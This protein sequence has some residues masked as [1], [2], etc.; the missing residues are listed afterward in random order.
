VPRAIRLYLR[1]V[2]RHWWWL[3]LSAVGVVGDVG[4]VYGQSLS[5]PRWGWLACAAIGVVLAQF[6]AWD[7]MRAERDGFEATLTA[8]VRRFPDLLVS[9]KPLMYHDHTDHGRLLFFE[10]SITNQETDRRVVL[11]LILR[12][13]S[14][15][16]EADGWGDWG[17]VGSKLG[18]R[19]QEHPNSLPAPVALGPGEFCDGL[20]IVDAGLADIY[21]ELVEHGRDYGQ[22]LL[23]EGGPVRGRFELDVFDRIS[24]EAKQY[25]VDLKESAD[26]IRRLR[27]HI[28]EPA[29]EL[30]AAI[31]RG[32]ELRAK[33]FDI[34]GFRDPSQLADP[35]VE[36][37]RDWVLASEKVVA[38]DFSSL[39][40]LFGTPEF[41][42]L[43]GNNLREYLDTRL[44]ELLE[45]QQRA[46]SS[47][48]R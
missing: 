8:G 5:I 3:V 27:E 29:R 21:V 16:R 28:R 42:G 35:V 11:D 4:T 2:L 18:G 37:I 33:Y 31:E 13:F 34:F 48:E 39:T 24:A 9:I 38:D 15:F 17:P 19:I 25:S 14:A 20:L 32:E 46:T 45:I 36:D 44:E 47:G 23:R 40:N 22:F 26:S 6:R 43:D 7:D 10:V 12:L 30:A 41:H 1:A